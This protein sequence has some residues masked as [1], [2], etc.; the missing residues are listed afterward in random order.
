MRFVADENIERQVVGSIRALGHEVISIAE[1]NPGILDEDII[2]LARTKKAILLTCDKDFGELVFRQNKT[3][4]GIILLRLSGIPNERKIDIIR[5]AI[6]EHSREFS[7]NFI[8]ISPGSVR[9]R[10][11]GE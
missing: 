3:T 1:T 10:K 7:P 11:S 9:I 4:H 2:S 5:S 8:V 6:E